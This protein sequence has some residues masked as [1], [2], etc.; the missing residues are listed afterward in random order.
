MAACNS[1]SGPLWPVAVQAGKMGNPS[2]PKFRLCC[3]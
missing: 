1:L 2:W 3:Y